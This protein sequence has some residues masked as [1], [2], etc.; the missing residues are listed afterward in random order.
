MIPRKEFMEELYVT[1]PKC[2]YNNKKKRLENFGTCL[3]CNEI[4]DSKLYF[5]VML[6]KMA[7]KNPRSR[8]REGRK[9]VLYF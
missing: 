1:C 8:N 2:G 7:I 6:K 9:A 4:L 3:L 5:K